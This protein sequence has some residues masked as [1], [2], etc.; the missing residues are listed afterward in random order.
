MSARRELP[1]VRVLDP[2]RVWI[3]DQVEVGAGCVLYPD[4]ALLGRTA[5]GRGSTLHQGAWL[6]DSVLGEGVIIEPYSVLDGAVVGDGCRVGPF[7]RLRPGTVLERNA[8]VGNF[9]EV[10]QSRLGEGAKAS[11]L[12]YLG[13]ADVGAG[14]NIG[15]GVVTC[16]YD[17]VA[18]HPT[19]I[20]EGAFVGSDTMLVAPVRVG[21][22][23]STAAGSVITHD[24]P[25]GALAVGRS[26]QRNVAGWAARRAAL[27]RKKKE[28]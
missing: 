7:A 2:A 17:G 1:G 20:G 22:Q 27:R 21:E 24:V 11:H 13:D 3:E 12:A 14:A 25:P 16:N 4:V 15:A 10:K 18:K 8:R 28:S 6:R 26:K 23:A 5:V 9:V 19:T